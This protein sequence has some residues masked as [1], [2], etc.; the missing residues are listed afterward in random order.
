METTSTFF[1]LAGNFSPACLI[2]AIKGIQF[3]SLK[4][5]Y[6]YCSRVKGVIHHTSQHLHLGE[7]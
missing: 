2:L 6:V 4:P 3:S 7:K 1:L 5:I